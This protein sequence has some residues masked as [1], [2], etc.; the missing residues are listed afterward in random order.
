MTAAPAV[1]PIAKV[2]VANRGEIAVR[3]IRACHEM[4]IPAAV[5]HTDVDR[6][7]RAVRLADE[8]YSIGGPEAK[9]SYLVKEKII[10]AAKACGA[11]AIHPGYGFLSENAAFAQAVID[12]G[13]I[14]IGPNPRAIDAMGDKIN[15]RRRMIEAGVPV[16]PGVE[17][18]SFDEASL[19]AA[20]LEIG[21]PV[22]LKATAGGGGKGIRLVTEEAEL[23]P[24]YQRVTSEAGKAFGNATVY[25]EKAVE[26]PH[27][28]EFQ[29]F[30]DKHGQ[31]IHLY[32]RE[33]SIQRRHQKVVEE[34]PS[35]FLTPEVRAQMAKAAVAAAKAIDYDNAGTIEFLVDKQ[36]KFY[37]LEMNTRLQVEHPITEMTLGVDLVKEQIR[38]A[39]GER[40]S[41][42]Q[43]DLVPRGHAIEVRI[44]AED[45]DNGY[46]P[47]VGVIS[48][49]SV[50]AGPGIRVDS[51]IFRGLEVSVYYDPMLA[52][53]IASGTTRDE[54]IARLR[55]A[56]GELKI[57]GVKTNV[58]LLGA[59]VRDADFR[60]G[61][62]DTKFLEGWQRPPMRED[63]LQAALVMAA[64]A[65][66]TAGGAARAATLATAPA[67]SQWKS[68]GR[69]RG[70][71]RT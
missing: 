2:L 23:W 5:V 12:A 42:K 40:L 69:R 38:V 27:H 59:I 28:I 29:V 14:W 34:T 41:W 60:A 21:L 10:A 15:S 46:L 48:A 45:P 43:D 49:V 6:H 8:A 65:K 44:C 7:S 36:R 57:A 20:A 63:L 50:P 54:A 24:A 19:R 62:Y 70:V 1:K 39:Q 64:L 58:P 9:S 25:L 52:K 66:H 16:I 22:M 17:R 13:L 3:V 56:L 32:E 30:G 61:V 71:R 51:A 68:Y 4:G 55:Q 18:A 33:C 31:V 47:D 35:P 11:D 26:G 53:L 67:E 37:F